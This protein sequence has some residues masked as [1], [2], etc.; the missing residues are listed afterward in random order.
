MDTNLFTNKSLFYKHFS[1][2]NRLE[3]LEDFQKIYK[4]LKNHLIPMEKAKINDEKL[5]KYVELYK[6]ENKQ[7]IKNILNSIIHIPFEKFLKD[8]I[9]QV[10]LF[11]KRIDK[12]KKYV[13]IIGANSASGADNFDF[14]IY[15]S[16]LWMFMLIYE[17]LKIKP[18]DIVLNLKIA[19]KLYGDEYEFLIVDD[20]MYSGQQMVGEVLYSN[21]AEALFRYPNSFLTTTEISK[22][23]FEPVKTHNIN[24]NLIIPYA[25]LT[26][27]SKICRISLM[28]S[29]NIIKYN[30][31]VIK[32]F[33]E[34][35]SF[36]DLDKLYSLY[37]NFYKSN[38]DSLVPIFFDH[39]ISD[40]LSTIEL[41][42][43]KG[44]VLDNKDKR[45]VFIDAC[46][47]DKNKKDHEKYNYNMPN[48]N[49]KKINCPTSPYHRFEK[50]LQEQLK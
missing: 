35:L 37:N 21:S 10:E 23:M 7:F 19:I 22:P 30:K 18:F 48:Y 3:R 13:Y 50:I 25:S 1:I 17:H 39:K 20:C 11:N 28:T 34:L 47:Y 45:L 44:Q 15:K 36:E 6:E 29:L 4:I 9:E 2:D 46:E 8:S 16:N 12:K 26:S 5:H 43:I 27:L 24:V 38:T 32:S 33:N 42:L 49:M 41:V 14:D 31:Y 40:S